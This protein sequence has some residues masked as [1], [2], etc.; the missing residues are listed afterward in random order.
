MTPET[1]FAEH[2][3]PMQMIVD[4]EM[5]ARLGVHAIF[6]AKPNATQQAIL[7]QLERRERIVLIL[8]NGKRNI[9]DIALLASRSELEVAHILVRLLKRGCVEFLNPEGS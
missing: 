1:F 5:M 6:C 9:Q 8:L 3:P 2:L 7:S 4:V